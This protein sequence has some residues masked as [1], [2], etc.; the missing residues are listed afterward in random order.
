MTVNGKSF[1][2]SNHFT[3]TNDTLQTDGGIALWL[4][5]YRRP[6][7]C[8]G[9]REIQLLLMALFRQ[10]ICCHIS[11]SFAAYKGGF[12]IFQGCLSI[13]CT[14]AHPLLNIVFQKNPLIEN[15]YLNDFS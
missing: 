4:N 15:L 1:G 7:Q 8:H 6:V 2:G 10:H 12:K 13:C 9:I 14:Y 3:N 5:E 11:G